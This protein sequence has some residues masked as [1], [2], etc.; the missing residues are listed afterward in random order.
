MSA[1]HLLYFQEAL[2]ASLIK[3]ILKLPI[4]QELPTHPEHLLHPRTLHPALDHRAQVAD[5]VALAVD[6]QEQELQTG[7]IHL[8]LDLAHQVQAQAQVRFQAQDQ[9]QALLPARVQVQDHH[10]NTLL[11]HTTHPHQVAA[12]IMYQE[13]ASETQHGQAVSS[14]CLLVID[15]FI[16]TLNVNTLYVNKFKFIQIFILINIKNTCLRTLHILFCPY[17][18]I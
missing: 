6:Y 7:I 3:Y 2:V 15:K 16:S 5:Q 10:L 14:D 17:Q 11:H 18:H 1:E 12:A 4:F 13:Q 8:D 9:V